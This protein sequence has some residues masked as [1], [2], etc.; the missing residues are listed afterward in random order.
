MADVG[1]SGTFCLLFDYLSGGALGTNEQ[2]FI[3]VACQT[4]H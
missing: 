1:H 4:R 3:L 2:D